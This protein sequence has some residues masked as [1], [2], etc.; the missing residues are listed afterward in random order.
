M[1]MYFPFE[2]HLSVACAE[3]TEFVLVG[4]KVCC[5]LTNYSGYF[6]CSE[7]R[8]PEATRNGFLRVDIQ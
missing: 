8:A 2:S 6:P 5:P 4:S 3:L 7:G 1:L